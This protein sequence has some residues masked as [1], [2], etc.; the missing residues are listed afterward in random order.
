MLAISFLMD[1]GFFIFIRRTEVREFLGN[2]MHE[3]K[4]KNCVNFN[5]YI[6]IFIYRGRKHGGKG[7]AFYI[8]NNKSIM[9]HTCVKS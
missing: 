9:P 6:Y 5:Q 2:K 1:M 7:T 8:K 3:R 4:N